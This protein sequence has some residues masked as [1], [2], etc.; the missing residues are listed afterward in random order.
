LQ[1]RKNV[2]YYCLSTYKHRTG[3]KLNAGDNFHVEAE[4]LRYRTAF[5]ISFLGIVIREG[6]T[7]SEPAATEFF[8]Q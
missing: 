7:E 2:T 6:Y 5:R 1:P 4:L 3:I 8:K